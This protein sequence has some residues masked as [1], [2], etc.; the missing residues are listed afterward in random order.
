M[1][2]APQSPLNR[3]DFLVLVGATL[4]AAACKNEALPATCTDI[5]S[6]DERQQTLR[7]SLVYVEPAA[8]PQQACSGCIQ[9]EAGAPGQCGACKLD[10]GPVSPAGTCVAFAKA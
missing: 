7:A 5:S 2:D 10:I 6:L 8:D 4:G 9:Y 3:R 1:S